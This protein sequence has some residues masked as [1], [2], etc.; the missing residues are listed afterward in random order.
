MASQE[1]IRLVVGDTPATA[2]QKPSG[3]ALLISIAIACAIIITPFLI[4]R[5]KYKLALYA[6]SIPAIIELLGVVLGVLGY[7]STKN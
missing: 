7:F 5:K 4:Y 1:T 3:L 6:A 2:T